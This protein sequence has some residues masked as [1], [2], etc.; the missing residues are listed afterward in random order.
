MKLTNFLFAG[1]FFTCRI[2]YGN[3]QS[4]RFFRD[5]VELFHRDG[6]SGPMVI[7]AAINVFLTLLNLFWFYKILAMIFKTKKP[8]KK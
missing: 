3:V 6:L 2:V 4:F 7:F 5:M 8:K 1:A